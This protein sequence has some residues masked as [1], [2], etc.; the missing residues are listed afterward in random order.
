V[1]LVRAGGTAAPRHPDTEMAQRIEAALRWWLAQE[2]GD[3][4]AGA[5]TS[6]ITGGGAVAALE[7]EF[8]RRHADRSALLL[9]SATLAIRSALDALA[10]GPGDE[11]ILPALD[12]IASRDAVLSLAAVPVPAAVDPD[13]LTL[14]PIAAAQVRTER[15]AAVV[16]C[17][18]H[19]V[20]ADVPALRRALP[21]LPIIED[22]A[23]AIGSTLDGQPVGTF[24]DF[25][26][27]SLGPGKTIDAGE[28]GIL[29]AASEQMH[30]RVL[31]RTAPA[32]RQVLAG[33]NP[34]DGAGGLTVRPHVVSAILGLHQLSQWDAV[35]AARRHREAAA[36]LGNMAQ[37][38]GLGERRE[39][40]QPRV[41][42]IKAS[43]R[44]DGVGTNGQVLA[45]PA[46]T[47]YEET[48]ALRRSVRLLPAV[49]PPDR[50]ALT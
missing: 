42:V 5:P 20:A 26:A 46:T 17:H 6:A 44:I 50:H 29:I 25:A 40:A 43:L 19:G 32:L 2:R 14:S 30:K 37:A 1:T 12:W 36:G 15:T 18:L 28:G 33:V 27:F 3:S 34:A 45:S 31:G 21:D 13:T 48:E 8:S 47:L 11:V 39:N 10:V 16:C 9:P 24:G 38:L 7:R 23:A 35:N 49:N 22:C 41:P 4:L